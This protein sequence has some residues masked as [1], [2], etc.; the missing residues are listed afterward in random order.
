V[1]F[2]WWSLHQCE[3]IQPIIPP[4][5]ALPCFLLLLPEPREPV[6]VTALIGDLSRPI[7][8]LDPEAGADGPG[9]KGGGREKYLLTDLISSCD[10]ENGA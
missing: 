6:S 9:G 3:D 8:R 10:Y 2:P 5:P 7:L 1:V 4:A